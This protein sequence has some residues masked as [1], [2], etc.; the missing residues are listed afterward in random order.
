MYSSECH[1][2]QIFHVTIGPVTQQCLVNWR[3]IEYQTIE[4]LGKGEVQ[5]AAVRKDVQVNCGVQV[6][7]PHTPRLYG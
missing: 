3:N 7:S 1:S 5:S 6:R 4:L 2:Q